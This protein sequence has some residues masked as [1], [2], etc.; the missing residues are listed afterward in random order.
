MIEGYPC[1]SRNTPKSRAAVCGLQKHGRRS[2]KDA[3]IRRRV[4]PPVACKHAEFTPASPTSPISQFHLWP[5]SGFI[6]SNPAILSSGSRR[7]A[8]SPPVST[9][10]TVGFTSL[11]DFL[12]NKN[13]TTCRHLSHRFPSGRQSLGWRLTAEFSV[14]Y[15]TSHKARPGCVLLSQAFLLLN[16]SGCSAVHPLSVTMVLGEN[17]L[18][19]PV[20]LR[21]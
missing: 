14:R 6:N 7:I 1:L 9:Y 12:V 13:R 16:A 11:G 21:R 8:R 4:A 20:R 17:R 15:S 2:L 10:L 19:R 18:Y 3:S 5:C